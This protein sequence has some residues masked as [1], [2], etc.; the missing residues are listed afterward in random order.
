MSD[1]I[2]K[3]KEARKGEKNDERTGKFNLKRIREKEEHKRME[4]DVTSVGTSS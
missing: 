2:V 3:E 4:V 1:S